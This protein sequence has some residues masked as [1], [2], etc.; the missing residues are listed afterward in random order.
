MTVFVTG[1]TSQIGHFLLPRL[2][3]A[4]ESIVAMSRT[5]QP[6]QPS[7]RWLAGSLPTTGPEPGSCRHIVSFGPLQELATWL[8]TQPSGLDVRLVATSSMS[9]ASKRD[10]PIAAERDVARRLRDGESRLIE[11]CDRLRIAW[12]ILRPTLLYGAGLDKSL[13]P[14]ARRAMR[15][16]VFPI[17]GGRGLRQPLHADDVA[18]AAWRAL[19]VPEAAGHIL[20]MGGGERLSV[21][22]MFERVRRSLPVATLPV[23]IP[24]AALRGA[25]CFQDGWRGPVQRLQSDLVAD[26]AEVQRL[27]GIAPRP[28]A[29][30]AAVWGLTGQPTT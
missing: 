18:L 15:W 30:T 14:I 12:T 6:A 28:F 1:A 20:D 23:V 4:G 11:Q 21:Q 17:P 10:S 29:P 24:D 8:Q 3:S 2:S 13:T 25:A 5:P 22:A 27:L 7:V 19:Q 26:N 9:A 16:R